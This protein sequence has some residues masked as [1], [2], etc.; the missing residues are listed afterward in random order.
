MRA[1]NLKL[2][3]EE[4]DVASLRAHVTL[5]WMKINSWFDIERTA[6][7]SVLNSCGTRIDCVPWSIVTISPFLLF[8]KRFCDASALTEAARPRRRDER[9]LARS[10]TVLCCVLRNFSQAKS[11]KWN[12]ILFSFMCAIIFVQFDWIN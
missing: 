10:F 2:E 3:F 9:L 8:F 12:S 11:R 7:D 4:V 6:K 1:Q 5:C